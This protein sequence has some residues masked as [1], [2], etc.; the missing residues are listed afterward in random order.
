MF[1][2][3]CAQ[4]HRV[5]LQCLP[6]VGPGYDA[7]R[8]TPD[9]RT[10]SRRDGKTYDSMWT[11]AV[12]SSADGVTITSYN[13]WHEGTQIEPARPRPRTAATSIY[14]DYG[15]AYGLV[16]KASENA[17]LDRTKF[18]SQQFLRSR[19]TR[20]WQTARGSEDLRRRA[21]DDRA[22]QVCCV[23]AGRVNGCVEVDGDLGPG[24]QAEGGR[25]LGRAE[26]EQ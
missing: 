5:G 7:T 15:G 9:L 25:A 10:K 14:Q 16:G 24:V 13:E 6:S 23:D 21:E 3:L 2:R 18:W 20:P 17:Y 22:E 8:A 26:G 4:A 11:A 12:Q 19:D 1:P